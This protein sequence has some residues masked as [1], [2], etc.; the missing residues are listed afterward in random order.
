[1]I[2]SSYFFHY[3][4]YESQEL[5]VLCYYCEL[6]DE[7]IHSAL[8]G[9]NLGTKKPINLTAP[10]GLS[11]NQIYVLKV[12]TDWSGRAWGRS[13]CDGKGR[14]CAVDDCGAQDCDGL[15][16]LNVTLIEITYANGT[17]WGDISIDKLIKEFRTYFRIDDSGS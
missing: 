3:Y 8:S 16:S 5:T 7:V 9:V 14:H 15:G 6:C 13:K 17:V 1:M 4:D 11:K 10:P 12:E 2:N